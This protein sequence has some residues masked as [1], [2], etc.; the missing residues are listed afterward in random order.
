MGSISVLITDAPTKSL[1][2]LYMKTV[3]LS[4]VQHAQM[5]LEET[6]TIGFD[7]SAA[8][9]PARTMQPFYYGEKCASATNRSAYEQYKAIIR[10]EAR[11]LLP[12]VRFVEPTVRLCLAGILRLTM[13][14][15]HTPYFLVMQSDLPL[16]RSLNKNVVSDVLWLMN[17]N[18]LGAVYLGTGNNGCNQRL[19][20]VV[21][22]RNRPWLGN[23]SADYCPESSVPYVDFTP[24]RFWSDR[25][26]FGSK[27]FYSSTVWP[28]YF[29][30][31]ARERAGKR[32]ERTKL[33]TKSGVGTHAG[34]TENFIFCDPWHNH[35]RWRTYMLG[36]LSEGTWIMHLD[37]RQSGN[38][39]NLACT[40]MNKNF[41][42]SHKKK[43]SSCPS[44][45]SCNTQSYQKPSTKAMGVARASVVHHE[46]EIG[47]SSVT[48]TSTDSQHLENT[49]TLRKAIP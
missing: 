46:S 43:A 26:H 31:E 18:L 3:L 30:H 10:D 35:S 38:K 40:D 29:T 42:D 13:Q 44:C 27:A 33:L 11:R 45:P 22:A 2:P 48:L 19:A 9:I 34:M 8:N 4:L 32:V 49:Q 39:A 41:G 7:G 36:N 24:M 5:L 1:S 6:A 15:V 25:V 17:A 21:C 23:A 47:A 12:L 16:L 37:S 14:S 20:N 28:T